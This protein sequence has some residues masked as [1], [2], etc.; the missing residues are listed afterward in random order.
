MINAILIDD[1]SHCN[2]SLEIELGEYC[3]EVSV[4]ATYTSGEKA[5][6][7]IRKLKP[8]LVF[9]DIEMPWINGFELLKRVGKLDFEV[10]FITAY[11]TYAIEAFRYCAIDYLLKPIQSDLLQEAVEKVSTKQR[12]NFNEEK[13]SALLH[14]MNREQTSMKIVLPTSNS[15]EVI[16]V[17]E[18][19][20]CQ[21]E[22]NYSH[23]FLSDDTKIFLA[24]S[25]KEIEN[26]I[27]SSKFLRVHQSHLINTQYIKRYVR[28]DGGY[29]LMKDGSQVSVS[30]A[31]KDKLMSFLKSM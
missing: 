24:K 19:T 13:L 3:P 1:E 18:I 16:N 14:N 30:K 23:V 26:I 28:S 9:L 10:I 4:M 12:Q 11:D 2:Q 22:N 5:I 7:G 25:L 31:N 17:D 20:R 27:Q 21:S 8:D 15:L 29:L 6:E